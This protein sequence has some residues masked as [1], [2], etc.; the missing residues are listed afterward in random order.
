MSLKD[1][2]GGSLA[3]ER[4]KSL[5]EQSADKLRE[6]ILLEKLP[7]GLPM[8]ERELS[9]L[10]GTSRTP[11]RDAIRLLEVEGLVDYVDGRLRVAD[12]SIE[13]LSHWLMIQG[14]LEGLAGE[15]ACR[16]ATDA[17]LAHIASLQDEMIDLAE[18]DDGLRRFE[19]DMEFHRAIVA[20]AHNPP[21]IE[22]HQQYNTRLWRARFV[23]SQRRPNRK[24]Q[25][26]KHQ[27][28]VDA[29]QARD[30]ATASAALIDHLR[31]AIGNIEAARAEL[32]VAAGK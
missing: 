19:I 30:G 18:Q 16:N 9:E 14:A 4:P 20:A 27:R 32:Q 11:V 3:A 15:Q 28:I 2:I 24:Q 22:T 21:L 7:A 1:L 10:L 25:M 13:T 6:L 17:E 26:A 31:N 23:S 5:A 12:P 8:N 29:L